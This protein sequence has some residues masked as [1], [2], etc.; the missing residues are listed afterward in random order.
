MAALPGVPVTG[1]LV[2]QDS[3]DTYA[4]ID[5]TYAKGGWRT[6]AT[7]TERDAIT[8]E[9]RM[10]GMQVY[11]AATDLIYRLGA[12]LT[13]ADWVAS[14]GT[15][16][17]HVHP[18]SDVTGLQAALDLKSPL[19][20]PTFTGTPA[21]PTAAP[22]VSTTQLATTAF[23]TAGD[24]VIVGGAPTNLNT[25]GKVA[26]A[27]GSDPAFA[28]TTSTALGLK[29]PLASPAF[30]GTPTAPT[31]TLG[32]NTTQLATT[33]FV[34]ANAGAAG[35]PINSPAFTGVPT[36]PTAAGGTATGQ[37]ATTLFVANAASALIGSAPGSLD[38]LGELANALGNDPA[39][40]TTNSTALGLKAPLA[41]PALTGTPTAP[42]AA[43]GTNTTQIATT[44]YATAADA[45]IVGTA[46]A[47]LNTLGEIATSIG[48]DTA[49]STTMTNAL[50]LKAPLAA[51]AFT[52]V[53]TAPTAAFGTNTTQLATTAFVIANATSSGAPLNSPA[54]T[55]TPTAP[56]AT[57]GTN[58]TQIA[59]TAFVLANGG[60][61]PLA[62]PAFTGVPTAPTASQGNNSTQLATT[63]YVDAAKTA[64][65]GGAPAAMDT[66]G[67]ISTALGND[68][69]FA[70]NNTAALALKAPLAS[71]TFTGTPAAPT[72]TT[73][74]ATTQL[75]TTLFVANAAAVIVGGAPG[76]MDTLGEISTSLGGDTAFAST[77]TT[78]LAGKQ[79]LNANLTGY[80]GLTS[81]ANKLG[82]FTGTGGAQTTADFTAQ[83][84]T[85]LA[86]ASALLQRNIIDQ[87]ITPLT[88]AATIA[89]DCSLGNVFSVTIAG[90]RALGAPTAAQSGASYM[91]L[92]KND[93]TAGRNPTLNAVFKFPSGVTWTPDT[94]ANKL[95]VLTTVYDGTN[96]IAV[97]SV[98]Y[99]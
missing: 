95:N 94:G 82:Y 58:T 43:P 87:G 26:T 76:G 23:A 25:L 74:T 21:A 53:P 12:G 62:S 5:M 2:P 50:A 48:N 34:I 6:V 45:V 31:A 79:G 47:S 63:A 46:P 15:V 16:S 19:A 24:T 8:A 41:N 51:P 28:S 84:R 1:P 57:V 71:P 10:Q 96:F 39:Y 85:L 70:T 73:G 72:A 93:G 37:L 66:L 22:G 35:A 33:A 68:A 40:A 9:R 91:W 13:N 17:P 64:V 65:V 11:V 92:I 42:T 3:L 97:P 59:T 54:F 80:A 20:S 38:T 14:S 29:A 75:A 44:A 98:G 83:A 7:T 61:A 56:T 49:F 18:I 89:T 4:V 77:M 86:Q 30:T 69:A 55:G 99:L 90:N 52:G 88:D 81:A 36:A 27:L 60:G 32:T 78:N 67:E